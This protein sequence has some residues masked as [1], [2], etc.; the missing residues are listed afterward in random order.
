MV[1]DPDDLNNEHHE[2]H[3]L[4]HPSISAIVV[5]S[6]FT[7][8]DEV[9]AADRYKQGEQQQSKRASKAENRPAPSMVESVADGSDRR[10]CADDRRAERAEDE[11]EAHV[12][13][14]GEEL[15]PLTFSTASPKAHADDEYHPHD[16]PAQKQ[17]YVF[18]IKHCF[19]LSS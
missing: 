17:R 15:F 1:S 18:C 3:Q 5:L 12:A 4:P 16:K 2:S 11:E 19:S 6:L 14:A 10:A 7:H 13:A 8:C 9:L